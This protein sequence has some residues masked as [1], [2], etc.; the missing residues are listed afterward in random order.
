MI[1]NSVLSYYDIL[2]IQSTQVGAKELAIYL[3]L[4]ILSTCQF[5]V[6]TH[7]QHALF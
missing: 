1:E 5:S 3:G 7:E 6:I 4:L 2:P